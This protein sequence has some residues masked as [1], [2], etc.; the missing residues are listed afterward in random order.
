MMPKNKIEGKFYPLT[1]S[2][3][4]TLREA[5]LTAAEWRIWSYL[6]ELDPWGDRYVSLEVLDVLSQCNCSKATFYRAI[7]KFQQLGLFDFQDKGFCV[8]NETGTSRLRK[9]YLKNET[10]VSSM[11]QVSQICDSSLKNETSFSNMRQVSQI[12][13]Q[14]G[15]E[16][17]SNGG[18]SS[19]QT[20]QKFQTNQTRGEKNF[21]SQQNQINDKGQDEG[22]QQEAEIKQ[23]EELQ[24]KNGLETI[25]SVVEKI[26]RAVVRQTTKVIQA[27]QI[28]QDLIN[29]LEELEIPL[30]ERV[31]SAIASHHLSQAYGAVAHIENTWES[32]NTPRGVFLFQLPR[33][34]VE[35]MGTR[36]RVKTARD[37]DF[38]LTDL[39]R[40]YGNNWR[41]AAVH[42]GIEVP[43]E[44]KP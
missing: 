15:T 38:T 43:E 27:P 17:L 28:P 24:E 9:G 37:F 23:E 6:V 39:K 7:A 14:Q 4:Q 41:N 32:I 25:A 11:R 3:A 16:T 35:V 22:N 12:C 44:D 31:R 21:F 5:N 29:K 26:P 42:F 36:V 10:T 8:K 30:D 34:P 33:Q 1:P 18:F 20:P 13:D 2:V 19:S 40:M